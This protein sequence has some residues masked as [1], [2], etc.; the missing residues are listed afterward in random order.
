MIQ[1][2]DIIILDEAV[3]AHKHIFMAIDRTFRDIMSLKDKNLKKI[4]FGGIKML[5]GGDFRQILP[6]TKRAYRSAIVQS[7]INKTPFWKYVKKYRLT[8]NM[9]INADNTCKNKD[10]LK[11]FSDFLLSIGDGI[12]KYLPN[13]K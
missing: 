2:T 9:R 8:I 1:Q 6:V 5:F 10:H 13:S 3:M 12:A 11:Q 4:S 7:C